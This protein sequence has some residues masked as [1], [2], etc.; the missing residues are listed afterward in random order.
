[1]PRTRS[2]FEKYLRPFWGDKEPHDITA[3]EVDRLRL[4]ILKDKAP[5]TIKLTLSLLR[6]IV[7]F[8]VKRQL[9]NPLSFHLEMPQVNNIKTEDLTPEQLARLLQ[10]L[11]NEVNVQAANFMKLILF[12]GMRRGELFRLQWLDIDFERGFIYIRYPKG[13]QDQK[14]PLNEPSQGPAPVTSPHGQPVCFP[15]SGRRAAS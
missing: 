1:M 6:R 11:E 2:R 5:Q 10:V 7:N 9:C 13:G 8:G 12:T 15:R 4:R 14:I 3:L